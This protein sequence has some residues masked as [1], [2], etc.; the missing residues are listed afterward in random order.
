MME[1]CKKVEGA[2]IYGVE[3]QRMMPPGQEIIIGMVRDAAF[4]PMVM[5][6]M[7]GIYV[8]LIQDVSFR[9]AH[10][11]TM[12]DIQEMVR[13]TKAYTLLKG[14]R[15][16]AASDIKALEDTIALVAALVEDFPEI[17]EFDINPLFVYSE[18]LSALDV[19]ITLA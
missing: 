8:N 1:S 9:L 5:F 13:E 11:L 3:I 18:G 2:R 6:G 12:E 7:G 16:A 19:K 10:N 14:Y 15:G 4:G 17:D